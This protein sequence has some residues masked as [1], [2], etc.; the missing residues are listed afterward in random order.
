MGLGPPLLSKRARVV[1][2]RLVRTLTSARLLVRSLH[3]EL[4]ESLK[5]AI[6]QHEG[7]APDTQS[8]PALMAGRDWLFEGNS[9]YIDSTHVA[10]V[11]QLSLE[12][13]DRETLAVALELT[14]YG[15][16]LSPLFQFRGEPPFQN[17]YVDHAVYLRALLGEEV[18]G[19]IAHFRNKIAES[20]SKQVGSSHAQVL[21]RLLARLERYSEAIEVSL[22][23]L[24]DIPRDQLAC[25]SVHQLC[26]LAQD[27]GQL[28]KLAREQGD[29][30]SFAAATLQA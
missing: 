6:T 27:F 24:R 20:D 16:C 5:R 17:L 3:G 19:A 11:V 18:E 14:D 21:V 8:I 23:H 4:V 30:L 13:N 29:L 7:Q 2:E 22:E 10:S 15:R 12:W 1:V 26:Q 28:R 9:Y 25:P